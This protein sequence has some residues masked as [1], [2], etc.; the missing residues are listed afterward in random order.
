MTMPKLSHTTVLRYGVSVL[1]V[2]LALI[3][4]LQIELLA[5]RTPFALFFAA[6]MVSTWYGGWKPGLLALA[7]AALVSDYF[8]IPPLHAVLS[9]R[10]EILE[11]VTFSLV[12]LLINWLT[13]ARQRSQK[14][15]RESEERS[16]LM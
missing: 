2:G 9:E 13:S 8:L 16:R 4:T 7:L 1:A 3:L 10:I 6:V 5:T 15:L 14:S 12:A 11:I